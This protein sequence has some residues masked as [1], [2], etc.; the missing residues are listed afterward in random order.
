[1]PDVQTQTYV[2]VAGSQRTSCTGWSLTPGGEIF[3]SRPSSATI[4]QHS[5]SIPKWVLPVTYVD[6]AYALFQ[7]LH[8]WHLSSQNYEVRPDDGA[9]AVG[10][11]KIS[12]A[13]II[14]MGGAGFGNGQQ[15]EPT[16]NIHA[17]TSVLATA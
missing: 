11:P 7:L 8:G 4:V 1:M 6:E 15:L 12:G 5:G 16:F 14:E 17:N 3:E 9:V 10:N 13:G 2:S